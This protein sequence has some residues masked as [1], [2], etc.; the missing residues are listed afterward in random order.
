MTRQG[1]VSDDLPFYEQPA[2]SSHPQTVCS[3]STVTKSGISPIQSHIILFGCP[4]RTLR[5]DSPR[6]AFWVYIDRLGRSW[7]RL[8]ECN[9]LQRIR[10]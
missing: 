4:V 8:L 5:G 1:D 10:W 2:P 3:S 7:I 6:F 9:D